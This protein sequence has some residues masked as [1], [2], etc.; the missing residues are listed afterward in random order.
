MRLA[1]MVG[2][3]ALA[4]CCAASASAQAPDYSGKWLF[5]GLVL[6]GRIALSFAQVCDLAQTGS[7]F[8]GLCRGPNGGCSVVG[9]V[10]GGE[11]DLTCRLNNAADPALSGVVTFHG[12]VAPDSVV[13]GTFVH[14]KAPGAT[15]Q[16]AMMRL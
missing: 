13:R 12:V 14:S 15:G 7:Q 5:S 6:S 8:A 11:V 2:L 10:N 1:K 4:A 3:A 16:A 9:V